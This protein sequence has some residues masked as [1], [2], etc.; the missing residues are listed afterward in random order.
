MK[1]AVSITK[2]IEMN[3]E[4]YFASPFTKF[5]IDEIYNSHYT[6]SPLWNLFGN[7]AL[8]FESYYNRAVKIV[9]D[10][11]YATHRHLIEPITGHSH[12]RL[13]LASRFLGFMDQIKKS[14]KII[15]KPLLSY[16][17]C[18]VRSKTGYNLRKI[19]LQTDKLNG[20]ELKKKTYPSRSTT[21]PQL[22]TNGRKIW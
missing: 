5:K 12:V 3:Q 18:D 22:K 20:S 21:P 2:N 9:F 10:L 17:Q 16:I 15:P 14:Q 19:M 4:F 13:T 1:R 11:L 8:Q 6:G 7:E